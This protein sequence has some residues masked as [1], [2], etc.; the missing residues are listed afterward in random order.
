[1]E[2][3]A[4]ATKLYLPPVEQATLEDERNGL[5][6]RLKRANTKHAGQ[7]Y[8]NLI[9]EWNEIMTR[10]RKNNAIPMTIDSWDYID[11]MLIERILTQTY[12]RTVSPRINSLR[13]YENGT[14][15]IYGELLP[16]FIT[17]IL[18]ED[19]RINSGS[20]FVDLGSGVGNV[21]LQIALQVGCESWGCEMMDNACELAA[22]QQK[23]FTERCRLWGL[24]LGNV[25]LERG[26]FLENQK[27]G[28]VLKRADLI[29]VNN[30]AFTPD[31]NEALTNLFLDAKEGC[32]I[33]SLKSFVPSGHK[34]TSRNLNSACNVLDVR[35]KRYYSNRVSWTN[36]PGKYYV[37]I[38]DSSKSQP[39]LGVTHLRSQ[40][41]SDRRCSAQ[42]AA[43]P[44]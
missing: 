5:L 20:V 15:N 19:A 23:E 7:D 38:K 41:R 10:L 8:V 16:K 17:D 3:V 32:R 2:V 37:S 33:V 30:Q 25:Q 31:L 14:D 22:L 34:I 21:V 18:K 26:N 28:K 40:Q 42:C 11:P 6:G 9:Q 27:I 35:E 24:T 13:Q 36:A 39:S 1:M 29:L 12:A 43:R 4:L 44:L